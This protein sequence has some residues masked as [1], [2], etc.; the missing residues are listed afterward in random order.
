MRIPRGVAALI[1]LA[2]LALGLVAC[3]SNNEDVVA[4]VNG[5]EI[6]KAEFDATYERIIS[7]ASITP[8]ETQT[9][10]YQKAVLEMMIDSMLIRQEAE[11]LK[12]DLSETTITAQVEAYIESYGGQE[13][14]EAS[15]ESAGL[16]EDDLRKIIKDQLAQQFLSEYASNET[17]VTEL[18]EDYALLEH[19]LLAETDEETAT[20]VYQK[21]VAGDD[22]AALALEYS[23]DPGT[24]ESGG[25]LGWSP[26]RAYVPAFK[27]AADALAV[28]DVSEPVLS[29]YGWHIIRKVDEA[30]KGD[31]IADVPDELQATLSASDLTLDAYLAQ[32]RDEAEIEYVD[33]TL[34][35]SS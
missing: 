1:V 9:V 6:T 30:A 18:P 31:A 7:Q 16:T 35:P 2:I 4:I 15:L 3:G 29:D 12:A 10:E 26:T 28:G 19:I 5:E 20:A 24:A 34:Q 33:E 14:F 25:S 8:D 22:F 27:A 21:V 23:I 32:L 17:S 13:Q 11:R